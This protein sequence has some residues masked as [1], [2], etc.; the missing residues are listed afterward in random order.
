MANTEK[1]EATILPVQVSGTVSPYP[2]VVTVIC[3][4]M[5]TMA[6][7]VEIF[8]DIEVSPGEP[9]FA[10]TGQMNCACRKAIKVTVIRSFM[11]KL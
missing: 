4:D 10:E 9:N 8:I 6:R 3:V 7:Y 2:M 11:H 5:V 1:Q